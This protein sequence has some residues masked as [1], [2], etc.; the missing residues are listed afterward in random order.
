VIPVVYGILNPLDQKLESRATFA[1]MQNIEVLDDSIRYLIE[2]DTLGFEV[3]TIPTVT[4]LSSAST[5]CAG[6]SVTLTGGG[7]ST[8]TWTGGVTNGVSFVPT[9]TTTYTVIGTNAGGYA[10]TAT[11]TIT[12]NPTPTVTALSSASTVCAGTSVTLTGGGAS[13]YTWSGGITNGVIFVPTST[14]TYTVTGTDVNGCTN[15]ATK[16]ITVNPTPT[17][18]ALSSASTVCAGTSVTLTGGGANTYTWSGGVTNGVSLCQ[19]L[20]QPIL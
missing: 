3:F 15:T 10:N 8:Y 17:V 18:T 1:F 19:R 7:A 16:T 11:I 6:T 13:T 4:A 14:T 2:S 12:V 20:R 5:V 9:A